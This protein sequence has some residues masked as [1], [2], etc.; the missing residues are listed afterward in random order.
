MYYVIGNLNL[1]SMKSESVLKQKSYVFALQVIIACRCIF[2]EKREYILGKQF[3]RSGTAVG[4]LVREAEFAQSR[5]DF[6]SK[7]SIAL[8]ESNET[9]YWISLL[10]DSE[11]LTIETAKQLKTDNEEL[12]KMLVSSI[13]TAKSQE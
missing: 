3:L 13:K 9:D 11:I 6:V 10:K 5:A 8:K 2:N 1:N 12:L 4:A 7:L